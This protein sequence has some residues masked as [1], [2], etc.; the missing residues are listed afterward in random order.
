MPVHFQFKSALSFLS[1]FIIFFG[2]QQPE[3]QKAATSKSDLVT[4]LESVFY[5]D[6]FTDIPPTVFKAND[7]GAVGDSTSYSTEA[8]QKAIDAAHQAGGGKVT[9]ADGIYLSGAIFLKSNVELHLDE[10]VTIRAIQSD[11]QYPELPSR[12]AGFEMVWPSAL[13]NVYEQK[14]V[15]ITG[16]GTIDGNG[17][18]WWDKFWGDP[19]R[20]GGMWVDY[21]KRNVRWAV[22]YDCKRVRAIVVYE[23]SD[24]QLK[25]FTVLRSGFWTV[26]LTYSKRV[27]VDGITI[28][29]NIGGFG[30][31][32]DGINTD[33]SS[34][35]LVEN[36][37]I[38]CNDDNLCIKA[39]R[40]ADGLRVNRP[41]ENIV[42]RN[43]ITRA[44]HGLFT[45]GSET[46]GGMR[47]IE[48]YGLEAKGTSTGIR[49]KSAQVRGGLIENIY[50]HDIK[51]QDVKN[52]FHFELNWYPEYSY[53]KIPK[54]I[55]EEDISDTWRMMTTKVVPAEKGIPEFRN[56]RFE[57]IEVKG[58][59]TAI[60]ANAYPQ[61]SIHHLKWSNVSIQ[62]EKGGAINFGEDWEMDSITIDLPAGE[63]IKLKGSEQI[64]LPD[65]LM[66]ITVSENQ[67]TKA[68]RIQKQIE[69]FSSQKNGQT[70]IPVNPL[71]EKIISPK[72]STSF[73]EEM[74]VY[75]ISEASNTLEYEEPL[76]DGFYSTM[77]K[78]SFN[79]KEK[80]ISVDGEKNHRW[81]FKVKSP[82]APKNLRGA[83]EWTYDPKE[84][85]L[86]I[87]KEASRGKIF[88]E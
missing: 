26:S 83:D 86:T 56:L 31:S 2:C 43:C 32:S 42:Y 62:A 20:S 36:C 74:L 47:N 59:T 12:I 30:P 80:S 68:E 46:S 70:I 41:S 78:I 22:D 9:F 33:S 54:E 18:F 60:Y 81:N 49:F 14:N 4:Q 15:R 24:V 65:S 52:P 19:P 27:H 67:L 50:F 64:G 85:W 16:E 11:D 73:S 77:V 88:I 40:D 28:K 75:I 51:M 13:I 37:D 25:D 63:V 58:A 57:D 10:N 35:I 39:G 45:I 82:V 17:K 71:T 48:V 44:G 55:P 69:Q 72:D 1:I 7:F 79:E 76:G 87:K 61:K 53:P 6:S 84:G 5:S 8:I 21:E 3:E 38:S 29:N 66:Q 23:S 34:E